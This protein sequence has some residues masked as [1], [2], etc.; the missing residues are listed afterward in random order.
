MGI[1]QLKKLTTKQLQSNLK[2]TKA[3]ILGLI[4]VLSFLFIFSIYDLFS[5]KNKTNAITYICT[6]ICLGATLPIQ[7]ENIKKI[8]RELN[9]RKIK[10]FE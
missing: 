8:K 1:L 5:S 6:A 4:L 10:N 2:L 3:I 9:K 7:L